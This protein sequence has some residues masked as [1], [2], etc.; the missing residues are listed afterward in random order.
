[1]SFFSFGICNLPGIR[2]SPRWAIH[3]GAAH[4]HSRYGRSCAQ[5]RQKRRWWQHLDAEQRGPFALNGLQVWLIT[6]AI[7]GFAFDLRAAG[8]K[9]RIAR[10]AGV[11]REP[12]SKCHET[13][14]LLV[15]LP[16]CLDRS[17]IGKLAHVPRTKR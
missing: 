5:C 16:D 9:S 4:W 15:G 17:R 7:A 11:E 13:I 1:M 14:V 12:D 2:F 8:C 10:P 3:F 6:I